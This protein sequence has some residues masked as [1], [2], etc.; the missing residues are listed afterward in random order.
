M[1]ATSQRQQATTHQRQHHTG[2]T[3]Q[4]D[5][6]IGLVTRR[7]AQ[8][9]G[10]KQQRDGHRP[11]HHHDKT[12]RASVSILSSSFTPS[13]PPWIFSG[14][15]STSM[16]Q[17]YGSNLTEKGR[18][19]PATYSLVRDR[20]RSEEDLKSSKVR[21]PWSSSWMYALQL[22]CLR[23]VNPNI[24]LG[25]RKFPFN[26]L[27]KVPTVVVWPVVYAYTVQHTLDRDCNILLVSATHKKYTIKI[28]IMYSISNLL[29]FYRHSHAIFSVWQRCHVLYSTRDQILSK[30]SLKLLVLQGN[31]WSVCQIK[32]QHFALVRK[33][34]L[35]TAVFWLLWLTYKSLWPQ[36][37]AGCSLTLSSHN[38]S[39]FLFFSSSLFLCMCLCV[40]MRVRVQNRKACVAQY[41]N[42]SFASEKLSE[43]K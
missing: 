35:V 24:S 20:K 42:F 9:R 30:H 7:R 17:V 27:N 1:A 16:L 29:C 14:L 36:G 8:R 28:F 12:L 2:S 23:V 6:H 43:I 40:C 34:T 32:L 21:S 37:L 10:S 18:L 33:T 22:P 19:I 3:A 13:R 38:P 26:W 39:L 41:L 11:G 5:E 4:K 31:I 15:S 25:Q